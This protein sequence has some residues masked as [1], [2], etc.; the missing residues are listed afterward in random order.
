MFGR[1]SYDLLKAGLKAIVA[2]LPLVIWY[3]AW[4]YAHGFWGQFLLDWY[5]GGL[6]P[7]SAPYRL[8]YAAWPSIALIGP[9]ITM[10][11]A[12]LLRRAGLA[13]PATAIA[14]VIGMA[15]ATTM[16]VW[17]E[18]SR[19]LEYRSL[20]PSSDV[21]RIADMSIFYAGVVGVLATIVGVRALLGKSLRAPGIKKTVE[22]AASDIFGHADWMDISEAQNLFGQARQSGSQGTRKN[23]GGVVI[24]EAYRVDQDAPGRRGQKFVSSDR[25]SWGKGGKAPL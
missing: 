8:A 13:L 10:G 1:L 2:I 16:T 21:L 5:R 25:R 15:A 12:L 23:L 19:L 22:R 3:P 18:A 17:P 14:G 4:R 20:H 6:L 9:A 11:A 24:G 7:S